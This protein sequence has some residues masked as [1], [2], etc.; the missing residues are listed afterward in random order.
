MRLSELGVDSLTALE[1]RDA[2]Q[3]DLGVEVPLSLLQGDPTLGQL[4][5]LGAPAP[6]VSRPAGP[7]PALSL[8]WFADATVSGSDPYAVL[9]EGAQLADIA[10]TALALMGIE[11]PPEMTGASIVG[12]A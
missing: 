12:P 3:T 5:G 10:P 6:S 4:A 8:F 2:L 11:Q 1:L 7:I 9:L